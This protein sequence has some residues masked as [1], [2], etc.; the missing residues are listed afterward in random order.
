MYTV[1]YYSDSSN[2]LNILFCIFT[3]QVLSQPSSSFTSSDRKIIN[4]ENNNTICP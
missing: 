2:S 3:I 1:Q 4:K